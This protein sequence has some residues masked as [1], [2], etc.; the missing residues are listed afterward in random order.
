MRLHFVA[1][2]DVAFDA[3][4][5]VGCQQIDLH[6]LASAMEVN[7]RLLAA[8]VEPERNRNHVGAVR[9]SQS[10]TDRVAAPQDVKDFIHVRNF[11]V[12]PSH[13][14][15]LPFAGGWWLI[16]SSILPVQRHAS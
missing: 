11:A 14:L 12:L 4:A 10:E 6:A 7:N 13:S 2:E 8:Q 5:L 16:T 9:A 1:E 3:H 15:G